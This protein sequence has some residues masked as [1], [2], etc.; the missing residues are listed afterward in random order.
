MIED[1]DDCLECVVLDIRL[2]GLL[3][4]C[5][6]LLR[7]EGRLECSLLLCT[8]VRC[9]SRTLTDGGNDD[10]VYTLCRLGNGGKAGCDNNHAQL[11]SQCIVDEVHA[12]DLCI[13]MYSC[14]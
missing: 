4:L 3:R 9:R 14:L 10:A 13:R 8:A 12:D 2:G 11:V 6:L 7:T 5:G 1:I